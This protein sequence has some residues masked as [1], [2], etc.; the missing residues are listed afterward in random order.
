MHAEEARNFVSKGGQLIWLKK[1]LRNPSQS[2]EGAFQKL[3]DEWSARCE[4]AVSS[5]TIVHIDCGSLDCNAA[6]YANSSSSTDG[7]KYDEVLQIAYLSG[8]SPTVRCRQ[9]SLCLV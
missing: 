9:A 7:L 8:R 2:V 6:G 1:D 4:Q 3:L 5:G